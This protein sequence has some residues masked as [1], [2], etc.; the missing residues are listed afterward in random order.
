MDINCFDMSNLKL[1][2]SILYASIA[3]NKVPNERV[4]I[5]AQYVF[6]YY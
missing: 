4:L 5:Y 6:A 3:D 2:A 1:F